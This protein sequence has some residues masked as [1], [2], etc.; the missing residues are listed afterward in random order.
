MASMDQ[1]FF[2]GVGAAL[3]MR[4]TEPTLGEA[5]S[6]QADAKNGMQMVE[7][8]SEDPFQKQLNEASQR[9]RNA[10]IAMMRSGG[11]R[12]KMELQI[13]QQAFQTA[14]AL[15]IQFDNPEPGAGSFS[16]A[17][18]RS[19]KRSDSGYDTDG[20][21]SVS[22]T[23]DGRRSHP[24][25]RRLSKRERN[26][27]SATKYRQK[28]KKYVSELESQCHNLTSTVE[29]LKTTITAL[30]SENKLLKEQMGF[31]KDLLQN[32]NTA[33]SSSNNNINHNPNINSDSKGHSGM[34]GVTANVPNTLNHFNPPI[35]SIPVPVNPQE[36]NTMEIHQDLQPP[37][38]GKWLSDPGFP[39]GTQDTFGEVTF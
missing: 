22:S 27:I 37:P 35:P 4:S 25:S 6:A 39:G 30:Q 29:S 9:L 34:T 28:K 12:Q 8:K 17:S 15:S 19:D 24:Y 1:N 20:S 5:L 10:Q 3:Q 13:A 36:N 33:P 32:R 23:S 2:A 21:Q 7:V 18:R 11:A 14:H 31:L 26:K 38:I 16:S